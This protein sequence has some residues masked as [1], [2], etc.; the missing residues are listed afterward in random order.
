MSAPRPQDLGQ[1]AAAA[2]IAGNRRRRTARRWIAIGSIP[3]IIVAMV[4]VVKLL[5]MFAAAHTAITTHLAGDPAGTIAAAQWQRPLNWFE[6]YKAPYNAGVGS[7]AAGRLDEARAEFDEALALASGLE[8]CAIRIN[9]S[10]V[11]EWMGDAAFAEGDAAT[12]AALWQEAL[13]ITLDTPEECSSDEADEQ[14]PDPERSL[15]DSLEQSQERL[16]EKLQ[17]DQQQEQSEQ[18][19]EQD[20]P[21]PSAD[22]LQDLQDRLEQGAQDREDLLGGDE[23]GGGTDRPW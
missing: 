16:E 18:P 12:A 6:P 10:L 23:G 15:E 11:V 20:Q 7:A 4:L 22:D 13:T 21:T 19:D 14:S 3:V 8:V 5:S 2:V 17:E 1:G 9:L